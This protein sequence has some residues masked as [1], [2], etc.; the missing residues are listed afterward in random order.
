MRVGSGVPVHGCGVPASVAISQVSPRP[1]K[2]EPRIVKKA[3]RTPNPSPPSVIRP[4]R[5]SRH[6]AKASSSAAT[7]VNGSVHDSGQRTTPRP[8]RSM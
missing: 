7:P 4:T 3:V 5:T 8:R 1:S 6:A 2:I